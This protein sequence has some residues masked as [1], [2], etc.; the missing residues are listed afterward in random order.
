MSFI[1]TYAH[2]RVGTI[3]LT[4]RTRQFFP[5]GSTQ[6]THVTLIDGQTGGQLPAWIVH[7]HRYVHGLDEW[8][9]QNRILPGAYITLEKTDDPFKVIINY[10][11]KREKREWIRVAKSEGQQ[12]RFEMRKHPCR[13][14]Y[15]EL[16]I[17][18][19]DDSSELDE[20]WIRSEVD[21]VDIPTILH[22]VF[23][24]LAKLNPQGTVHA[25]TIYNAANIVRRCPPGPIFAALV[26]N[27][28]FAQVGDNYWLYNSAGQ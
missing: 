24:E 10:A 15:D 17:I 11:S 19:E 1:L 21:Q 5:E 23:L 12:L 22:N 26:R 18:G 28:A 6:H 7:Q 13:C 14:E 2:Y 8:Y 9:K 4:K 25:K 3:P 16:M 20:L 27:E